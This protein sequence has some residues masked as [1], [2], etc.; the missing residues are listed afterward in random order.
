ML[1]GTKINFAGGHKRKG[2]DMGRNLI[3]YYKKCF[4]MRQKFT[5]AT[6]IEEEES[7]VA[8]FVDELYD[9]NLSIDEIKNILFIKNLDEAQSNQVMI[10]NE[11][12]YQKA[13]S[14]ALKEK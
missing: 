6:S 13:I 4:T 8:R 1:K 7:I 12:A 3:P 14:K 2:K 9:D 5:E 10:K 11:E